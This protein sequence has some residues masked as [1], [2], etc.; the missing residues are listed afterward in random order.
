[1]IVRVIQPVDPSLHSHDP[2]ETYRES[3][4]TRSSSQGSA[5]DTETTTPRKR[6]PYVLWIST[7]ARSEG[8][9]ETQDD[10]LIA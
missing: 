10:M 6:A 1:M 8:G 4:G 2:E 5:Y 3:A 9:V 7:R